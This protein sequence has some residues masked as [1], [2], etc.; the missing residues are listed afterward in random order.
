MLLWFIAS[1]A[2]KYIVNR[3]TFDGPDLFLELL[4]MWIRISVESGRVRILVGIQ[5]YLGN[6]FKLIPR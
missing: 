5:V 6:S 3:D 2:H 1:I 4:L